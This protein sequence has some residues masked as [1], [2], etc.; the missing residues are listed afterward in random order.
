M[1]QSEKFYC[2]HC[3][4]KQIATKQMMIKKK[5]KTLII[6]LKRFKIDP[7]TLR[8]SKLSYRI[9]FPTELRI[10]SALDEG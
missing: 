8:Y 3:Q 1:V 6:H 9:P 7:Q 4:T 10:E 2:E 5:P